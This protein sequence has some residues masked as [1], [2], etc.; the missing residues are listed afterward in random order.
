MRSCD[1]V[2]YIR[3]LRETCLDEARAIEGGERENA[4]KSRSKCE[5]GVIEDRC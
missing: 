4:V 2:A 3:N 5:G 1:G